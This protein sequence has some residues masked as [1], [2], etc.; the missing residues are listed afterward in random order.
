MNINKS[1][2]DVSV[3]IPDWITVVYL[4]KIIENPHEYGNNYM[5]KENEKE[6]CYKRF[7][8]NMPV[9]HHFFC[10]AKERNFF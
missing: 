9:V 6:Y 2:G 8:K 1:S 7:M 5:K 3:P 10:F 4:N